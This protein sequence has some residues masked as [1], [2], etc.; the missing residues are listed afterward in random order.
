MPRHLA[1]SC[2]A[3]FIGTFIFQLLGGTAEVVRMADRDGSRASGVVNCDALVHNAAR[4]V[5]NRPSW[6]AASL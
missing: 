2:F 5:T 1:V 4:G 3:E 6:A